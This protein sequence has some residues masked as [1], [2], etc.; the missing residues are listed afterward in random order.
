MYNFSPLTKKT[1]EIEEWLKKELVGVRTSRATPALL[2]GVMVDSYGAK[3]PINQLGTVSIEDARTLRV[4]LWDAS[5][6]KEVEKAIS[7]ANLGLA[8]SADDRGVRV[9]FPALTAERRAAILKTAKEKLEQA[10]I[11]LRTA[12][13][14]VWKDIQAKEKEGG[15]G[16]DEKF[17]LK[18]EMQ[19]IVDQSA[20]T[21]EDAFGR[22]EK[23]INS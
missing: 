5:A 14:E 16:E 13:D 15:M 1:K 2:D 18:T 23:E 19:K 21:L 22:K 9:S 12:R 11:S 20:K 17:R 7:S 6:Q 4:T 10:R 3:V 8:V